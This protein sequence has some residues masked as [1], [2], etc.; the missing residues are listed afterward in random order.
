MTRKMALL[1]V[2]LVQPNKKIY[3]NYLQLY[4]GQL[5]HDLRD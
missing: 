4:A 5:S 1:A 2:F 3:E